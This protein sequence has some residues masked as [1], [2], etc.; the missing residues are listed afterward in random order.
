MS[1]KIKDFTMLE[2]LDA[3]DAAQIAVKADGVYTDAAGVDHSLT[4]FDNNY[5]HH[6]ILT[7]FRSRKCSLWTP[8]NPENGFISLFTSWWNSRKDLYLKQAYAYTLKYN[9]IENYASREV[10]TN[11]ITQHAKGSTL[12]RTH[13]NTDTRTHSDTLTRTHNDTIT[14]TPAATTDATTHAQLTRTHTPYGDTVTT[15]PGKISTH[16]TKG[17]NSASFVEVD[18]DAE[19][20]IESVVTTHQGNEQTTDVYSGTDSVVHTT[21]TAGSEAHTGTIADAHTGT[22]ADAHTGMIT[23]ANSG[24][25]TDTRNYTLTKNGNIGIQTAAEM[26][27]REFNGLAQDLAFRALSEFMDKYTFYRDTWEEW[28]VI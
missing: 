13:N 16:S 1:Y 20:G 5:F 15:T 8:D 7:K 24:T 3:L 21:Q 28:E 18:K 27:E 2:I 19:S 14:D 25:D 26:L 4:V 22:I 10:M 17:F 9:P 6:N 23:D 12:T 11:D